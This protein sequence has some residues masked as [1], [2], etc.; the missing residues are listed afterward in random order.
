M[1]KQVIHING[2]ITINVDVSVKM[3]CMWNYIWNLA[4]CSSERRKYL[5]SIMNDSAITC[6]KVIE[7]IKTFP[8]NF[9]EKSS[10]Q[11]TKFLYFTYIFIN[12]C[13]IIDSC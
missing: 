12:Y 4:T 2:G 7:E 11:K 3:S 1:E 8:T 6:N 10:F 5:E 9:N 13:S